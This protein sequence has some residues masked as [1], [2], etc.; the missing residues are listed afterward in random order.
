MMHI[1]KGNIF[2]ILSDPFLPMSAI[3]F[4]LTIFITVFLLYKKNRK[5]IIKLYM[6]YLFYF[7][8]YF[9]SILL[10]I[11]YIGKL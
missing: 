8:I 1:L 5:K 7:V 3:I 4:F 9:L 6:L 10:L 11:P 2:V